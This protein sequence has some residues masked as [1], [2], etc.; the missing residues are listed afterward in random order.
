MAVVI[1]LEWVPVECDLFTA[2]AYLKDAR[3]PYLY[4]AAG[5]VYC[6]FNCPLSVY[7]GFLAAES[8]GR[9]FSQHIRSR[10]RHKLVYHNEDTGGAYG[11]LEQ[12]LSGSLQLA[13]ARVTQKRE[14]TQAAGVEE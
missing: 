10:F 14:A 5:N 12:Q 13:K 4:F 1:T 8:K 9:Y 11:N 7:R 6:Y 2:A 3:Q